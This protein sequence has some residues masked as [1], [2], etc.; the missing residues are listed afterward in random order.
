MSIIP[1]DDKPEIDLGAAV[2]VV[3]ASGG[4]DTT[5]W[6]HTRQGINVRDMSDFDKKMVFYISDKGLPAKAS[7][8]FNPELTKLNYG[9]EILFEMIGKDGKK[10]APFDDLPGILNPVQFIND[11]LDAQYPV[12]LL[13]PNFLDPAMKNGVIEPLAIRHKMSN[14]LNEGPFVA[15]DTRAALM[16]TVGPEISGKASIISS[17]IQFYPQDKIAPYFDSQ[18]VVAQI[19][20]NGVKYIL[21]AEGYSYPEGEPISPFNDSVVLNVTDFP[22]MTTSGSFKSGG[23]FT[24][25]PG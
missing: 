3:S 20:H 18:D 8:R 7:E 1:F 11:P 16:P 19:T 15:H 24:D 21:S 23:L 4:I 10:M 5:G 17:F 6:D 9:N 14:T 25:N 2:T 22:F 12:V 13:S